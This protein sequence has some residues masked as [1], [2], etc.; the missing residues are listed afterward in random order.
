[1]AA[2][3]S[4]STPAIDAGLLI[5]ADEEEERRGSSLSSNKPRRPSL[6]ARPRSSSASPTAFT[7]SELIASVNTR[8]A[9]QASLRNLIFNNASSQ[10]TNFASAGWHFRIAGAGAGVSSRGYATQVDA[11]VKPSSS[12]DQQPSV[13]ISSSTQELP[14]STTQEATIEELPADEPAAPEATASPETPSAAADAAT[15]SQ[16]PTPHPR[17]NRVRSSSTPS[18]PYIR[19]YKR[20][21]A[22]EPPEVNAHV[23]AIQAAE[24]SEAVFRAVEQYQAGSHHSQRGH[25]A[26]LAALARWHSY[27]EPV[28]V[29]LDVFE[30]MLQRNL[31]PNVDSYGTVIEV[32]AQ[33]DQHIQV[34]L[35]RTRSELVNAQTSS[36]A[37]ETPLS[38]AGHGQSPSTT[39]RQTRSSAADE[40]TTSSSSGN[41]TANLIRSLRAQLESLSQDD[42]ATA[43]FQFY[44]ALGLARRKELPQSTVHAL[45]RL[46]LRHQRGKDA[47]VIVSGVAESSMRCPSSC[48]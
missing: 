19:R 16:S 12:P 15:T 14:P 5:R 22:P 8:Q 32:L 1:M 48:V 2:V 39:A 31:K 42:S 37:K 29:I 11:E 26:A 45:L 46:C 4:N 9:F 10:A 13:L 23:E 34:R 38:S 25:N 40:S 35:D 30:D 3:H 44:K 43:A 20:D 47:V 33:R 24:S 21:P 17:R 36:A 41:P 7:S 18:A 27:D 28:Q 6:A